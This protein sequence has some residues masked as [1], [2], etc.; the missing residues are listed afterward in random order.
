MKNVSSVPNNN[1]L[2]ISGTVDDRPS[3]RYVV[4]MTPDDV[5]HNAMSISF[6]TFWLTWTKESRIR[7]GPDPSSD[8]AILRRDSM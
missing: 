1:I 4:E 7:W 2:R 5:S 6:T 3:E 8:E